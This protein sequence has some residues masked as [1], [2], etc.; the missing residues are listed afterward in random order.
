MVSTLLL[1]LSISCDC[2][3]DVFECIGNRSELRIPVAFIS[4]P[5]YEDLQM[6]V[7]RVQQERAHL[8]RK[9]DEERRAREEAIRLFQQQQQEQQQALK[10]E[11]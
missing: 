10:D 6:S 5:N 8:V 11:L 7:I 1:D 4:Q 3:D 9:R 2:N